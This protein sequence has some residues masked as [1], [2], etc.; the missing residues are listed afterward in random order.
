MEIIG[1]VQPYYYNALITYV[2]RKFPF[3]AEYTKIMRNGQEKFIYTVYKFELA[4][5][6]IDPGSKFT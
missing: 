1:P 5:S 4:A 6:S 2:L 3:G